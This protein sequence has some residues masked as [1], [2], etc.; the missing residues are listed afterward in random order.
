M[1]FDDN[2]KG[3]FLDMNN[4]L[5]NVDSDEQTDGVRVKGEEVGSGESGDDASPPHTSAEDAKGGSGDAEIGQGVLQVSQQFNQVSSACWERFLHVR[6]IKV[7]IVE[8][9]DSTRHVVTAL[10][11]NCNY[12]VMEATNGLHAWKILEDLTN[13]I[14]IVLSEVVMPCLS[15]FGLLCK[16]MRHKIRKN[17][18]VIM[19][20]SHNSMGLVFK[21]LSKG[22]VD[23]L[24]KPIRKNE[25]RNLWQHVWRRCH[26]SSGSGSES[27]TQVRNSK[28]SDR[29][30]DESGSDD[31]EENGSMGM[32]KVG[33]GSNSGSG[34]QSSWTKQA[35]ELQISQAV[36]TL[37]KVGEHPDS[38]APLFSAALNCLEQGEH[39]ENIAERKELMNSGTRTADLQFNWLAESLSKHSGRKLT[40]LSEL[41]SNTI[42]KKVEKG[43]KNPNGDKVVLTD[44][45]DPKEL[46]NSSDMNDKVDSDSK[47][48][49]AP[50]IILKRSRVVKD[51]GKAVQDMGFTPN[52]VKVAEGTA[53]EVQGHHHILKD[54][55]ETPSNY[56]D[57]LFNK[58][59]PRGPHCG[60]SNVKDGPIEGNA[61]NY[62]LNRSNGQN[63][64]S[65]VANAGETIE[66]AG[67][68]G[69]GGDASGSGSD[70]NI[71]QNKA[72]HREARLNKF[73]QKRKKKVRYHSR[74]RLEEQQPHV[75]G[76]LF[77]SQS[78]T[79]NSSNTA[80]C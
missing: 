52:K 28:S 7:L 3:E 80:D 62:S 17:I 42:S 9:D 56:D 69:G 57:L 71:D 58:L 20:S 77:V 21:C 46:A 29:S 5:H 74:E 22:A 14:D 76:Q 75:R 41:N 60:S 11:R 8:N 2:N 43:E 12:E 53:R 24:V 18:P 73:H 68:K 39:L 31:L 54:K 19:M 30:D 38:T 35:V 6:S 61:G 79:E 44:V 59:T 47:C 51:S 16:I 13:H 26:S 67:R 70:D 27:G 23:F 34:I 72:V 37:D 50:E 25:L 40:C 64:I 32:M 63:G 78:D 65:T 10:L 4:N 55:P 1:I 45:S 48:P 15:G 36:P 33:D 49:S 66:V